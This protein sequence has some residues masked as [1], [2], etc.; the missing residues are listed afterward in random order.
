MCVRMHVRACVCTQML[1]RVRLLATPW[2][3]ACRAPLSTG[4]SSKENWSGLPLP[5]P[6]DHPDPGIKPTSLAS[7]A[8]AGGL[9]TT[10]ATWE[11]P[12]VCIY[13]IYMLS[14]NS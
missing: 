8:L 5:S 13:I 9:F 1:S 3:I 14:K 10:G 7:P 6:G 2:T 4:F 11:A 12:Y